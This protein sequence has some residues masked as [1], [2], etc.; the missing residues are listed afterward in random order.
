MILE[1]VGAKAVLVLGGASYLHVE[2]A[3]SRLAAPPAVIVLAPDASGAGRFT[4]P[5]RSPGRGG[6]PGFTAPGEAAL[7]LH[8]SGTSGQKTKTKQPI[9]NSLVLRPRRS[10][11][12]KRFN[13]SDFSFKILARFPS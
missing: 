2:D 12:I 10:V 9:R 3:A 13:F 7:V 1:G 6:G 11:T 4:L 8:T 5:P